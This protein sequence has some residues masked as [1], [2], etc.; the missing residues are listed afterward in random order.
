LVKK[1]TNNL[2]AR[3]FKYKGK[4]YSKFSFG[5]AMEIATLLVVEKQRPAWYKR[6]IEITRY[7]TNNEKSLRII[8]IAK[9][10]GLTDDVSVEDSMTIV[11]MMTGVKNDKKN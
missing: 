11:S 1:K 8:E 9:K 10:H 6:K 4:T 2:F 3:T 7:A 5:E